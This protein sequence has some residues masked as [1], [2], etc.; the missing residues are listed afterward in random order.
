MDRYAES[1]FYHCRRCQ[2]N[3]AVVSMWRIASNQA[4]SLGPY[5]MH[6]KGVTDAL[7]GYF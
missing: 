1:K 5:A 7:P 6:E 2:C 3:V 4:A